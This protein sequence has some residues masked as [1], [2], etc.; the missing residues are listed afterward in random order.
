MDG[1]RNYTESLALKNGMEREAYLSQVTTHCPECGC[2]WY[3]NKNMCGEGSRV[4]VD[5]GQ[6]WWVDTKY[7]HSVPLREL[8]K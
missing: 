1:L 5:C 7:D 8:P 2:P 4:C 3:G 6:D